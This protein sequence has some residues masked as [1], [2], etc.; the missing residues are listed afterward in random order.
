MSHHRNHRRN[1]PQQNTIRST[2]NGIIIRGSA[3]QLVDKYSALASEAQ[4]ESDK[5]MYLQHAEHYTRIVNERA[6]Q[7][8]Q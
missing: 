1:N 8:V 5:Q 2:C 6:A 7:N 4:D 3:S